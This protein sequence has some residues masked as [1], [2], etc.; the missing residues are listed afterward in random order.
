MGAFASLKQRLP[1]LRFPIQDGISRT[2]AYRAATRKG[3]PTSAMAEA[4]GLK[5]KRPDLLTLTLHPSRA[6]HVPLLTTGHRDDFV[7]LVQALTLRNEPVPV[8]H[9]QG[10]CTVTG[11]NNWDR[12]RRLRETWLKEHPSDDP[13]TGW[14]FAF[15]WEII[16]NKDLSI[17]PGQFG[18]VR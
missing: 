12:V 2:D 18:R 3:E 14:Q 15:Q 11:Y 13:E 16:P 17:L 4:T 6:G 10:A 7:S 1:Q 9:S 5:L 8:P